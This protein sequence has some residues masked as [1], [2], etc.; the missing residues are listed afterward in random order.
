MAK[1]EYDKILYRLTSILTKLSS[2]EQPTLSELAE[3]YNVSRR[4]IQRDIYERLNHFPIIVNEHKKIM[5]LEGFTLNRTKLSL[6]EITTMSLSLDMI[7]NAGGEFYSAS[8]NLMKKFLYQ[9][10]TNPYFIKP[11]EFESIDTDSKLLNTLEDAIATLNEIEIVLS[12]H[13]HILKPLKIINM[14]GIW[15]LLALDDENIVNYLI[16]KIKKLTTLSKKFTLDA[17]MQNLHNKMLSPFFNHSNS[18]DV[19]VEVDKTISHYFQLKKQLASQ[20][21]V[22]EK[23]NGNIVLSF[24]V[25]HEEDV[26]NL[27]K[28]WLPHIRIISPQSFKDRITQ[29]LKQYLKEESTF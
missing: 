7:K 4:T 27:I 8:E 9:D 22:E 29:E 17:N 20:K 19:V 24:R 18:F 15:Y 11:N 16:S 5:F 14:D 3:E 21:T 10:F 2:V 13:T 26:D 28:S 12:E 25:S 23:E 1:K 6:E